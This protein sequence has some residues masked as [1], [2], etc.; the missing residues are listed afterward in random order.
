MKQQPFKKIAFSAFIASLV[1][2]QGC[3]TSVSRLS[4]DGKSDEIIFPDIEKSA[5][6]K[7]GTFPNIDN[8]RNVAP[9]MTKTQLYALLGNPHFAEGFGKVRE[10][11]YIFNFRQNNTAS[12]ETCQYKIIYNPDMRLQS[13]YWKPESCSSWLDTP[14]TQAQI[15]TEKIVEKLV[16]G[17]ELT[18]IQMS[19]DGMF[20]FDQSDIAHLRPGGIEK[21]NRLSANLLSAGEMTELKIFGHTDRLGDDDYNMKLSQARADTIR[22]Y[23]VGKNIP[24]ER[25]SALGVGESTPLVECKQNHRDDVLI[26]CLEPNRRFEI[27]AWTTRKL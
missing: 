16:P 23:L 13:T 7:Q 21:L 26:R 11:D 18:K 10:W 8:L 9:N 14:P 27:E 3:A 12:A 2:L 1:L 25:I 6:V 24:A 20:D 22:Q 5:W 17:P 15:V 4:A 19:A